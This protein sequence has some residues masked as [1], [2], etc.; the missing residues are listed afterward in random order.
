VS[1][2]VGF[3]GRDPVGSFAPSH[4]LVQAPGRNTFHH[5]QCHC[6]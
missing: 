1:Y 6:L 2:L 5:Q 4:Y 3:E